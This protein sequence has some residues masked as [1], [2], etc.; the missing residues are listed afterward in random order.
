MVAVRAICV[1]VELVRTLANARASDALRS[2]T[3]VSA[4]DELRRAHGERSNAW[5][6]ICGER[7][8]RI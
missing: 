3:R 7:E 6:L 8:Q 1:R 4:R 2:T 5:E